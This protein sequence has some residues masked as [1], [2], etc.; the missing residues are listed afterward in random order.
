MRN[1]SASLSA[2][3]AWKCARSALVWW[4]VL[5]RPSGS[6]ESRSCGATVKS[7]ASTRRGAGGQFGARHVLR[8]L[9]RAQ[10]VGEF[11]RTW[12]LPV[13][14][15]AVEQAQWPQGAVQRGG[16]DAGLL[17]AEVRD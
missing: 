9:Q 17:V 16:D 11:F 13:H 14:E 7:P 12:L 5:R 8:R 2:S 4:M 1:A 10:F 15:I 3:S 6:W